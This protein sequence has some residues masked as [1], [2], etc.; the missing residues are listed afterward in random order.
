MSN[1]CL[2]F[3]AQKECVLYAIVLF[4]S[5]AHVDSTMGRIDLN[6]LNCV[7]IQLILKLLFTTRTYKKSVGPT[8][9][10]TYSVWDQIRA[11]KSQQVGFESK[12]VMFSISFD[13][14]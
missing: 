4:K 3:C 9:L 11:K 14:T 13:G 7:T 1:T 6:G 8:F 10:T 5:L 2:L 12:S